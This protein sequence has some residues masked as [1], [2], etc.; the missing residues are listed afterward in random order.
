MVQ[1]SGLAHL[2][3]WLLFLSI[4]HHYL[5]PICRATSTKSCLA[6][7]CNRSVPLTPLITRRI[8]K[9]G[10]VSKARSYDLILRLYRRWLW[11]NRGLR[12]VFVQLPL[13]LLVLLLLLLKVMVSFHRQR[14]WSR[15]HLSSFRYHEAR[16]PDDRWILI[17]ILILA[18][19]NLRGPTSRL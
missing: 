1:K 12:S 3:R 15:M 18:G 13:R 9:P 11:I 6:A 14:D 5:L 10:L 19:W 2:Y 4:H 8:L 7:W 17:L 16:R